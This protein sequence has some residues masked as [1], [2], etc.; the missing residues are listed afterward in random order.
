MKFY[1]SHDVKLMAIVLPYVVTFMKLKKKKFFFLLRYFFL[2][3][4]CLY[5]ITLWMIEGGALSKG[6]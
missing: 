6:N 3:A 1:G 5:Y 2:F 4:I